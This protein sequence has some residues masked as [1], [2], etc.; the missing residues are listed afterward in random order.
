MKHPKM[1][2]V[3]FVA[4]V[5]AIVH[6]ALAVVF[7][8]CF[9]MLMLSFGAPPAP[10]TAAVAAVDNGM[11]FAV[12]APFGYAAIGFVFGALMAFLFN[13]FVGM[14]IGTE[15]EPPA[16]ATAEEVL[17]AQSAGLGDAA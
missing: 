6:G 12:A 8:P 9:S 10:L 11:L 1:V 15:T 4:K 5:S 7:I 3:F 14:L 16:R 17:S 2:D 13:R